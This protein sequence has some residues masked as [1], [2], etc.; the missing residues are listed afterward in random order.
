MT[1]VA[2]EA[3]LHVSTQY[4]ISA[5]SLC[6]ATAEK[7]TWRSPHEHDDRERKLE[8]CIVRENGQDSLRQKRVLLFPIR[9]LIDVSGK[10]G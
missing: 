10:A 2:D 7:A 5:Y 3:D 8:C 9:L 1:E 4:T 6:A